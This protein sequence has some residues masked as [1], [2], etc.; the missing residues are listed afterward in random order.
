MNVLQMETGLVTI[1][2]IN[3]NRVKTMSE[4]LGQTKYL[5]DL[6]RGMLNSFDQ[7]ELKLIA[8]DLS[9]NWDDLSGDTRPTKANALIMHFARR[10]ELEELVALLREE[11]PNA[12]WPQLPMSMQQI[13]D[14]QALNPAQG[15]WV[16]G[17]KISIGDLSDVKGVAIGRESQAAS[18]E[19]DVDGTFIQAGRDVNLGKELRDEHYYIALNWVGQGRP[20]MRG[21]DLSE[22]DLSG[23]SLSGADLQEANLHKTNLSGAARLTCTIPTWVGS[24][25]I[26]TRRG[27]LGR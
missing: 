23:V 17:D 9:I 21:F 2:D 10:G 6:R 4:H 22:R 5:R 18:I 15:D 7:E 3:K 25:P 12:D 24:D 27:F 20:R 26:R 13:I 8:F 1:I 14:E 19:G 11:R 16:G